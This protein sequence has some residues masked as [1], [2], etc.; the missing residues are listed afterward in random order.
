LILVKALAL[1]S[2]KIGFLQS[3]QEVAMDMQ[4][5][6]FVLDIQDDAQAH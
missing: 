4:A 6:Q 3:K 5:R 2:H 1:A